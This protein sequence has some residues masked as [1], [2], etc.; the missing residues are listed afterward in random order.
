MAHRQ[1]RSHK[2]STE[3]DGHNAA[4]HP[5]LFA[6]SRS[7]RDWRAVRFDCPREP[8]FLRHLQHLVLVAVMAAHH[9][10]PPVQHAR[11]AMKVACGIGGSGV[12]RSQCRPRLMRDD[13]RCRSNSDHQPPSATTRRPLTTP[14]TAVVA[15]L[16]A[17]RRARP[18]RVRLGAVDLDRR[19]AHSSSSST[20][21]ITHISLSMMTEQAPA[22]V[23]V[24]VCVCVPPPTGQHADSGD[25]TTHHAR[26]PRRPRR[27]PPG[28]S[29]RS[30]PK[31]SD[32]RRL[33]ERAQTAA[34]V[35]W[36]MKG[37]RKHA[38]RTRSSL[39]V[40]NPSGSSRR[41][42]RRP[43]S[44]PRRGLT[45][46]SPCR[47]AAGD[48]V[49]RARPSPGSSAP[50]RGGAA[51]AHTPRGGGAPRPTRPATAL[52]RR[53]VALER[54]AEQR[55]A[56]AAAAAA[57]GRVEAHGLVGVA[58][59]HRRRRDVARACARARARPS[60]RRGARTGRTT[61]RR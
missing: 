24:C 13:H 23:C 48:V 21:P 41:A 27:A 43:A 53:L 7:H 58:R 28:D 19:P 20:P 17:H 44:D 60:P 10:K 22:C 50:R 34:S 25:R 42:P 30:L 55:E 36:V 1:R 61:R 51:S 16:V 56:V 6:Q 5:N 46:R 38:R 37:A 54:A 59:A 31:A 49:G 45:H 33:L 14:A 12:R 9:M 8:I 26:P 40:S 4:H 2:E 57:R 18:P 35:P 32:R 3:A 15:G 47:P 29:R 52:R 11:R 39:S